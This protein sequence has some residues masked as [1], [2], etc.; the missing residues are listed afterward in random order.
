MHG[1]T[2]RYLLAH[3]TSRP[4]A[5]FLEDVYTKLSRQTTWFL[6]HRRR[7]GMTLPYY[8]HGNDSGWDNSTM[9]AEGIPLIAP[10]LAALLVLQTEV[11][12]EL[13]TE[14]GHAEAADQWRKTSEQLLAGLLELWD[15]TSFVPQRLD[16]DNELVPVACNSLIPFIP[17]LLGT[18]LA[19]DIRERL[20]AGIEPL[21]TDHGVA[22]EHPDSPQYVENGYWRGPIWA[23]STLLIAF[24]LKDAGF[25]DLAATIAKRFCTTC[26]ESGFAENFN[27]LTGEGLRDR[28]YTWTSSG[29]QML[30]RTF[31]L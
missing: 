8:L 19:P 11:L 23:P 7:D 24:G 2:V 29:F 25:P 22:T 17:I 14:L 10:D 6:T 12:S 3:A 9:F 21:V 5:A 15:G 20:A 16:L 18:R 4:A 31:G 28:A 26:K 27:A 30:V 1:W 13:A